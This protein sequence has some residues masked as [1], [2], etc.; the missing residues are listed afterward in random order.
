M[1]SPEISNYVVSAAL[2]S[3]TASLT[4]TMN[5]NWFQKVESFF[6]SIPVVLPQNIPLP[7]FN[8]FIIS[9]GNDTNFFVEYPFLGHSLSDAPSSVL[10]DTFRNSTTTSRATSI[11]PLAS[12]ALIVIHLL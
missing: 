11:I 12:F 7:A 3:D 6:F 1:G 5:G 2:N 10:L 8:Y 4:V 9:F